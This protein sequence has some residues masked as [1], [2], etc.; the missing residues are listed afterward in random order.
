E[1][2]FR[3]RPGI[4]VPAVLLEHLPPQRFGVDEVAVVSQRDAEWR[5]DVEGLRL[6]DAF[7][8]RGR[9]TAVA[10]ADPPPQHLHAALVEDVAHQAIALVHGQG[11][12]GG[13]GDARRVLATMLQDGQA[14]VQRGRDLRGS[15][16][17]DDAAH[18]W[19]V[20]VVGRGDGGRGRRWPAGNGGS[21]MRT[22]HAVDLG[23]SLDL[24]LEFLGLR[25]EEHT[26][27]L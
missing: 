14:V 8:A 23:P 5:V 13:G 21:G 20:P 17:A 15:N 27:E 3:I 16:D 24:R 9:I 22:H 25:S 4:D 6:V 1:Q 10:D 7:A 12:A 2:D 18:G 11:G 19:Y 26:S